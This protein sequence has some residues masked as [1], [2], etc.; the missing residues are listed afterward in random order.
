MSCFRLSL[1]LI[2]DGAYLDGFFRD[3]LLKVLRDTHKIEPFRS[4]IT[5]PTFQVMIPF[6]FKFDITSLHSPASCITGKF[7]CIRPK[8]LALVMA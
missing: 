4:K 2:P 3:R 8:I 7:L 1:P 6:A 5:I